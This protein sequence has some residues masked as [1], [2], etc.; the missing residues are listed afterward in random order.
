MADARL[1][2]QSSA[3]LPTGT[4]AFSVGDAGRKVIL[5]DITVRRAGISS[6]GFAIYHQIF[7]VNSCFLV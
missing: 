6:I 1:L 7:Q 5:I 3:E 4:L 2:C